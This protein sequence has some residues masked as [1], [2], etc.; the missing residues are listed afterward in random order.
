MSF[1]KSV[2]SGAPLEVGFSL[3]H[4]KWCTS[5]SGVFLKPSEVPSEAILCG[6]SYSTSPH[7]K[8]QP[9]DVEHYE[10]KAADKHKIAAKVAKS[11]PNA[12]CPPSNAGNWHWLI[13]ISLVKAADRRKITAEVVKSHPDTIHPPSNA[14]IGPQVVEEERKKED[15][16]EGGQ[17]AQEKEEENKE[18]A[19]TN[20]EEANPTEQ[21]LKAIRAYIEESFE[22]AEASSEC[23]Y[24][25]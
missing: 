22:E 14:A 7:A 24:F 1:L 19:S 11:H 3:S 5:R 21:V 16:K 15:K 8:G 4:P 13:K 6:A 17:A 25:S 18:K 10:L 2:R 23:D 9:S 12:I 20:K